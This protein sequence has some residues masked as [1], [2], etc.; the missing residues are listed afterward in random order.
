MGASIDRFANPAPTNEIYDR[1]NEIR[2]CYEHAEE[3]RRRAEYA[4]DNATKQDYLDLERRWLS[5]IISPLMPASGPRYRG[6]N[7]TAV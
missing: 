7:V 5:Q 3:C 1:D 2:E 6:D 4:A